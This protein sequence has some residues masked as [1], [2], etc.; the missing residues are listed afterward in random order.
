MIISRFWIVINP[1]WP[2]IGASPNGIVECSCCGRKVLEIKCPYCHRDSSIVTAAKEDSKIEM[3]GILSLDKAHSYY[4]YQVQ[5]RVISSILIFVHA[6]LHLR[7]IK[8]M[9]ILNGLRRRLHSEMKLVH[10]K[11]NDF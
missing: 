10:Q 1:G 11:Q 9:C 3:D 5:M 8:K 2:F 6:H 4:Y 7:V